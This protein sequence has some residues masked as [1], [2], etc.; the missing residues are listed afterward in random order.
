MIAVQLREDQLKIFDLLLA[1]PGCFQ[2]LIKLNQENLC[3]QRTAGHQA[4][5]SEVLSVGLAALV[6][7]GLKSLELQNRLEED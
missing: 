6:L 4:D 1:L 7:V 2:V 3:C 5:V